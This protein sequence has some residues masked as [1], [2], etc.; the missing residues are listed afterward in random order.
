M[1]KT[2]KNC[3]LK[4]VE[5][6]RCNEFVMPRDKYGNCIDWEAKSIFDELRSNYK[7]REYKGKHLIKRTK[8]NNNKLPKIEAIIKTDYI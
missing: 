1:V 3:A 5:W 8:I 4:D 6:C 7:D 2:C